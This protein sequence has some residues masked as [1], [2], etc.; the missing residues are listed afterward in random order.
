MP[1][2]LNNTSH[3][4]CSHGT[5]AKHLQLAAIPSMTLELSYGIYLPFLR[6][7][8]R[9]SLNYISSSC[10]WV[11]WFCAKAGYKLLLSPCQ[12]QSRESCQYTGRKGWWRSVDVPA[13]QDKCDLSRGRSGAVVVL[14][15]HCSQISAP[16]LPGMALSDGC[17]FTEQ[18][19]ICDFQSS[20]TNAWFSNCWNCK[21]MFTCIRSLRPNRPQP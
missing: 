20:S 10:N 9:H 14:H 11:R 17:G 2:P 6:H 21:R 16:S 8:V 1:Q 19:F 7:A 5:A 4:L 13:L 12:Q 15:S 18:S 3:S